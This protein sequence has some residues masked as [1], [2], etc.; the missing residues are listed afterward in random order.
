MHRVLSRLRGPCHSPARGLE[1][2]QEKVA[3]EL[4]L[5]GSVEVHQG[6]WVGP[7]AMKGSPGQRHSMSDGVKVR[8]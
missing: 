1:C 7:Q 6:S 4:R 2:I 8:E 3:A 5:E